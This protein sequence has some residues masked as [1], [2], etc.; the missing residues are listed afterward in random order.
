MP[1]TDHGEPLVTGAG[2]L[3]GGGRV[4]LATG[5]VALSAGLGLAGCGESKE[6]KAEKKVCAAKS[7]ISSRL[8]SLKSLPLAPSSLEQAK[9]D[10]T[11]ISE[12]VKKIKE[13]APDLAQQRRQEV[14]KA[15][16]QFGKQASEATEG[17]KSSG[18]LSA[19]Q[20]QVKTA[21]TELQGAYSAALEPIK[22]S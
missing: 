15:T 21:L 2:R 8:T 20:S 7:D 11:A 19:A 18:S 10:V 12:D 5:L 17:L 9:T 16:E 1:E 3:R 14:E 6:Q 22:C 4:W 13:A